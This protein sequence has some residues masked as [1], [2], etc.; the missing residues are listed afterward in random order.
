MSE[1]T[2]AAGRKMLGVLDSLMAV[3][4]G[5]ATA[6]LPENIA[7]HAKTTD[8]VKEELAALVLAIEAE[9]ATPAPLDVPP[10]LPP[11]N[12]SLMGT[13]YELAG[14]LSSAWFAL[15][16]ALAQPAAPAEG[17]PDYGVMGVL[18]ATPAPLMSKGEAD[19]RI[20]L[21]KMTKQRDDL[22]EA[23]AATPAPLDVERLA[24]AVSHARTTIDGGGVYTGTGRWVPAADFAAAIAAA[25]AEEDGNAPSR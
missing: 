1:P 16:A 3:L 10:P 4:H 19:A 24:R 25:Y 13:D 20:D 8:Q 17:S 18:P 15:R 21:M 6:D 2:T 9:A 14:D 22:L 11:A 7:A 5:I 12:P 23:L